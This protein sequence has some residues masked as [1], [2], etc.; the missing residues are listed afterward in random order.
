MGSYNDA[1]NVPKPIFDPRIDT[2][3]SG[4]PSMSIIRTD[5]W[6]RGFRGLSAALAVGRYGGAGLLVGRYREIRGAGDRGRRT[7]AGAIPARMAATTPAAS[8]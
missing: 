8:Q 1:L 7:D 5:W 2:V 6:G 3:S 4:L